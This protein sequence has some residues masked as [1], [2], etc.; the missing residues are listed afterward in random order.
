MKLPILAAALALAFS[1]TS[2]AVL[3]RPDGEGVVRCADRGAFHDARVIQGQAADCT[4][5]GPRMVE[6]GPLVIGGGQGGNGNVRPDCFFSTTIIPGHY[7]L[8]DGGPFDL[9][10]VE[11]PI[12]VITRTCSTDGC[13]WFFGS[14]TC[15][16]EREVTAGFVTSY[17]ILGDCTQEPIG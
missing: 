10:E 11:L 6:L 9:Q 15:E 2:P 1:V 12:R 17:R 13:Y 3:A 8:V 16:F 5:D 7:D 4:C 14:A